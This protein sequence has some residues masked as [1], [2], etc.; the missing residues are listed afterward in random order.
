MVV[1]RNVESWAASDPVKHNSAAAERRSVPA[2]ITLELGCVVR[3]GKP[4]RR[5]PAAPS[6]SA[7]SS[8]SPR[9]SSP[10]EAAA[11]RT[12]EGK[13]RDANT[14][15]AIEGK[16]HLGHKRGLEFWQERAKAQGEGLPQNEFNERMNDPDLYQIEDPRSN[17]SHEYELPKCVPAAAR[18]DNCS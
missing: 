4:V 10:P 5:G 9:S 8:D 17:M 6:R 7:R 11:K 16:Y 12:P 15:R 2:I 13:F 14:G 18:R 3:H 1:R